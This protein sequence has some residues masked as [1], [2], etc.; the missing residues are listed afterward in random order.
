MW[1]AKTLPLPTHTMSISVHSSSQWTPAVRTLLSTI[2]AHVKWECDKVSKRCTCCVVACVLDGT[3][4]LYS[5]SEHNP[6][7]RWSV[8]YESHSSEIERHNNPSF[9][10]HP[11]ILP[12]QLWCILVELLLS[13]V[14][15][16]FNVQIGSI[17]VVMS[18]WYMYWKLIFSR[19]NLNRRY[20]KSFCSPR[21]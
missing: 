21:A 19:L 4:A 6:Q 18:G 14:T 1:K 12:Q 13:W 10:R 7:F 5:Y 2:K 9:S 8:Y 20:W 11:A 3:V 15:L 16:K 17:S